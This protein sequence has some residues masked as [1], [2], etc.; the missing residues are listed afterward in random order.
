MVKYHD[1]ARTVVVFDASSYDT[2]AWPQR[3]RGRRYPNRRIIG[4]CS[5]S[6][7]FVGVSSRSGGHVSRGTPQHF[8]LMLRCLQIG[9]QDCHQVHA[10]LLIGTYSTVEPTSQETVTSNFQFCSRK[11]KKGIKCSVDYY[12][13]RALLYATTMIASLSLSTSRQ[14]RGNS[15]LLYATTMTA[16]LSLCL[17]VDSLEKLC[18]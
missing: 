4:I 13:R 10:Y 18:Q 5:T 11:K 12:C 3:T 6:Y 8:Y 2:N 1:T 7:A 16:S 15:A 9:R 17:R 14:S